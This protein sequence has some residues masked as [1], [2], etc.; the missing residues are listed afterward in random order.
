MECLDGLAQLVHTG[1][2]AFVV[3]S[4]VLRRGSED[5]ALRLC[6]TDGF[7]AWYEIEHQ[8]S[9]WANLWREAGDASE[10]AFARRVLRG[11][12]EGMLDP[13]QASDKRSFLIRVDSLST[14]SK[15]IEFTLRKV[16]HTS[17]HIQFLT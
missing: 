15:V 14:V 12:E 5:A 2:G 7:V 13:F 17:A 9:T 11:F 3:A 16:R 10:E 6:V 4:Q 8:K 1:E